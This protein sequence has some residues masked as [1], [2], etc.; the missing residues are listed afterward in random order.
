MAF[1]AAHDPQRE[2]TDRQHGYMNLMAWRYRRQ[3]P[4]GLVPASKPDD[5]P[6]R[7]PRSHSPSAA[8]APPAEDL[9]D[10]EPQATLFE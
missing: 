8:A 7:P 6:P 1:L 5:L 10:G 2:L 4:A 3:M 9:F